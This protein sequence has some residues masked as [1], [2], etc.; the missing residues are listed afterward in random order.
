[1]PFVAQGLS[2]AASFVEEVTRINQ[3]HLPETP[4]CKVEVKIRTVDTL[5]KELRA[6]QV[7]KIDV[8]GFELEVLKG[9]TELLFTARPTLIMEIHPYQLSLSGGSEEALFHFLKGHGYEWEIIDRN[10]NLLYSII[11]KAAN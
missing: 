4:I 11:A 1:M 7:I 10:P 9:A 5:V 6:P 2:N 3:R 8:E